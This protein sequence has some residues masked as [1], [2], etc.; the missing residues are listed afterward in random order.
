MRVQDRAIHGTY[1]RDFGIWD[2]VKDLTL[3]EAAEMLGIDKNDIDEEGLFISKGFIVIGLPLPRDWD[4]PLS[5]TIGDKAIYN[6]DGNYRL[7]IYKG[8]YR[9]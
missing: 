2:H 6:A 5:L 3:A 9:S 1:L 4:K 7:K 8:P